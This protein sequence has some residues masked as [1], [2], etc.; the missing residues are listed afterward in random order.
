[1]GAFDEARSWAIEGS[2][3][4]LAFGSYN[5]STSIMWSVVFAI[6]DFGYE[7]VKIRICSKTPS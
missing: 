2:E 5:Y 6:V 7:L 1:M 3:D 4:Y